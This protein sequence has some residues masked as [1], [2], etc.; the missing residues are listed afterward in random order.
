MFECHA[1][2]VLFFSTVV[3]LLEMRHELAFLVPFESLK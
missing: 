1:V 3:D 2:L